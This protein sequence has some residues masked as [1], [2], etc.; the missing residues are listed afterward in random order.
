VKSTKKSS[1]PY[2]HRGTQSA[3]MRRTDMIFLYYWRV[4]GGLLVEMRQLWGKLSS[5]TLYSDIPEPIA[6]GL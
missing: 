3:L 5:T 2:G 1:T 6:E 4:E